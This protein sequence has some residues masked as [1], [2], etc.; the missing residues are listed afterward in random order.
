MSK[1][2]SARVGVIALVCAAMFA[3]SA[4]VLSA[5]PKG[6]EPM[7]A[8]ATTVASE[9]VMYSFCGGFGAGE[10]YCPG[11]AVP[12]AGLIQA[13]DGNFYGTT[14]GISFPAWTGDGGAVF[15]ITPSG[16]LTTLYSFC[17]RT[18]PYIPGGFPCLDGADPTGL[19]QGGDGNFYGT[20]YDGGDGANPSNGDGV[21]AGGTVFEITPTGTLTTLYSFCN[22]TGTTSYG[23]ATCLDGDKPKGSLI[24]AD[25]GNFYGTTSDG[26]ANGAGTVF[27]ITPSGALTTLYSF[28]SQTG[29][30]SYGA[31]ICL[32][33]AE[34]I[35][36]LI[37]G[38][39]GNF[40]GTTFGGGTNGLGTVFQVTPAGRLTVVYSFCSQ[41]RTTSYGA[42]ICLDGA[43]LDSGL[44]QGSD[45]N[46]YGTTSGGGATSDNED[47]GD[48]GAGTVFKMTPTGALTT[49]YSFCSLKDSSGQCVDGEYPLGALIQASDGNFYGTTS[50]G[51][52][53]DVLE[54]VAGTVFRITPAGVLTTLYSFCS[55]LSPGESGF[56]FNGDA[57][58][59]SLIQASDGNFYGTTASGGL[60]DGGAVFKLSVSLVTPAPA[61][62]TVLP[63]KAS[64]GT[65]IITT[66]RAQTFEVRAKASKASGVSS[67]FLENF[68]IKPGNSRDFFI[69]AT[70]SC[71]RGQRLEMGSS[72]KIVVVYAP[73]AKTS[74]GQ[75]D[76]ATLELTTNAEKTKPAASGGVIDVMLKGKCKLFH[77]K[78]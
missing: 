67:V 28:C 22:Q 8:A 35:A 40:Y 32:D 17:S 72:C 37:Q 20:T 75:F 47:A 60:N 3:L 64:F 49:L 2:S 58:Q 10:E 45:G 30:T 61:T 15:K 12:T 56:C 16:A 11:G 50:G 52:A 18:G 4:P 33:G 9:T 57:P 74:K 21:H 41:A 46:F 13:S 68:S 31:Y 55:E 36:G 19:I 70:T 73:E 53:S 7:A 78:R 5:T 76:T 69:W 34:P 44:I 25:D 63:N 65:T 48:G 27:R 42:P 77:P 23:A 14:G 59:G 71:V 62:L 54:S 51:G 38:T 66:G 39:D 1:P 29:T 6:S 26:G 43:G 24:Q